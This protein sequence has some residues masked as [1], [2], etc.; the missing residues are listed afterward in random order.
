MQGGDLSFNHRGRTFRW[1]TESSTSTA[2]SYSAF[3]A[4][5][6]H[7]LQ[8]ITSGT[9]VVMVYNLVRTGGGDSVPTAVDGSRL[10]QALKAAVAK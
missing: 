1:Q 6:E 10:P 3:Y 7:E 2:F 4:D 5:V 8:P 9:R